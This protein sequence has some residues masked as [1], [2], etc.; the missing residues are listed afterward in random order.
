[1][2]FAMQ[3]TADAAELQREL[4]AGSRCRVLVVDDDNL[5]RAQLSVLLASAGYEVR[6]TAS[7]LEAIHLLGTTSCQ[8]LLTDWQLADFSG[9]EL[10]RIARSSAGEAYPYI[11]M[12]TV[13]DSRDDFLRGLA[14]GADD[15]L[16]KGISPALLLARMAV[17]R[18]ITRL[19]YCLRKSSREN[20]RLAVTDSLT[21]AHNRRYLLEHLPR[22]LDLARRNTRP[23]ALIGCDIDDLKGVNDRFGHAAGDAVLETFV[24]EA[25]GCIR[26]GRDWLVRTDGDGFVIVLPDTTLDGATAIAELLQANISGQTVHAG[27]TEFAFSVSIGVTAADSAR[28]LS[29]ASVSSLLN[30]ADAS[31]AASRRAGGGRITA[32]PVSRWPRSSSH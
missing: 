25:K 21:G 5:E 1:M 17:G 24:A 23:L 8:I 18:R 14:A 12:L 22:E 27:E 31:A 29:A 2:E 13:R 7:G 32:G 4:E 10:C 6:T 19:D 26:D 15:F 9:L 30:S 20:L 16:V 11:V 3:H 28:A